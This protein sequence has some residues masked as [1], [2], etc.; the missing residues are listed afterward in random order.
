MNLNLIL[1]LKCWIAVELLILKFVQKHVII[2]LVSLIDI[3]HK[4]LVVLSFV[5][6]LKH[7]SFSRLSL[8]PSF[9][10]VIIE[11]VLLQTTGNTLIFLI[12]Y[13]LPLL[14][15]YKVAK[16][17]LG[18]CPV[19]VSTSLLE[20]Y[21]KGTNDASV[22]PSSHKHLLFVHLESNVYSSFLD[23]SYFTMLIKLI[24]NRVKRLV[25]TWLQFEQNAHHEIFVRLVAPSIIT[26]WK[27]AS[28]K[29]TENILQL[30]PPFILTNPEESYKFP[31]EVR[32]QIATN[33]WVL[34]LI[35]QFVQI[36]FFSLVQA[37]I[38]IILPKVWEVINNSLLLLKID[39]FAVIKIFA[40]DVQ[41]L[42]Q[43][44]T[45]VVY[46]LDRLE[47]CDDIQKQADNVWNDWDAHEHDEW[48][49]DVLSTILRSH[50]PKAHSR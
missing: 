31:K 46:L 2:R 22:I 14:F 39:L 26:F 9:H 10:D 48:A 21:A 1:D 36:Q 25:K 24:N 30:F 20:C 41:E 42:L 11:Y 15:S 3:V 37:L 4:R 38:L 44:I 33:Q 18:I 19:D 29:T 5:V 49:Y 40:E 7:L 43:L 27:W 8:N 17:I 6:H 45:V 34:Q 50:I 16:N 32:I 47:S 23:E 13:M 35:R 12:N 28:K